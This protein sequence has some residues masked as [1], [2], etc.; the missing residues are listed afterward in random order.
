LASP[1]DELGSTS[2]Q[3]G[4][5]EARSQELDANYQQALM[6]LV[7]VD[8][9]V[10]RY[11]TEIVSTNQR[12]T[13][14]QKSIVEEQKRLAEVQAQLNERQSILE[15]RLRGTYKSNDVGYLEVV[16]GAGDFSD[17][18]NRVD[19][20]NTI[21]DEDR[22]IVESVKEAKKA[23]EEKIASLAGKQ[24][25]LAG[26]VDQLNTAQTNLV[27]AH[28]NQQS[29]V[30]SLQ[31]EKLANDGQL[32]QL[33]TQAASIEARM[34]QMQSQSAPSGGGSGDGPYAPPSGGSGNFTATAYCLGGTTATGMPVG[35][36]IIAVDPSVI[37]LGS[38]VHV[39]GYGDAIAADTGGAINGNRIDVWLPCGEA[40]EWGV[41]SVTVTY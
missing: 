4:D 13:E 1:G 18:L 5:L 39:S 26:L 3:I 40:Y 24:A 30:D 17:F 35:R 12:Q 2:Q 33:Q 34:S 23:E 29:V 36:G 37:P 9:E 19:M 8:S 41:R 6:N 32:N 22:N 27:S 38:R 7:A 16:M 25:E 11:S 14:I 20:M 28:A 10:N 21:A 31:N 15:K